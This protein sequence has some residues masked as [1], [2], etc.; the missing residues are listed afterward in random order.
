MTKLEIAQRLQNLS[1]DMDE[2]AGAMKIFSDT[3]LWAIH[4]KELSGAAT[5][6]REWAEE[7]KAE[8]AS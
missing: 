5:M 8:E 3:P 6:A 4:S 7:I 2:I 1:V